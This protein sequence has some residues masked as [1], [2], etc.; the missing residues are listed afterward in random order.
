MMCGFLFAF[1]LINLVLTCCLPTRE[2][3]NSVAGENPNKKLIF[4]RQLKATVLTVIDP[5][6]LLFVP[7]FL[8]HGLLISFFMNVF[9]TSLQYSTILAKK[10]PMLTAYYAFAMCSGTTL[11]K[12]GF[13]KMIFRIVDLHMY[14]IDHKSW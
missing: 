13:C 3:K 9:P 11:C 14:S 5:Y 2:V 8:N 1:C 7:R 4:G 6:I 12:F 10:Y